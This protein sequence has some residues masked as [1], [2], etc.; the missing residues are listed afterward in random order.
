MS[1]RRCPQ[2]GEEYSD[3]YRTCPFCEEEEALKRGK[4]PHRRV[5]RRVEKRR[6]T[7]GAGGV[8]LLLTG[9]IILGVVGYV[10]FGDDVADAVGIRLPADESAVA[11]EDRE[12]DKIPVSQEGTVNT[13]EPVVPDTPATT[14]DEPQVNEPQDEEPAAPPAEPEPLAL[15][16]TDITI[17]AGETGRLT[18]T[19][20]SG[21]ITWTSSNPEIASVDGGAVTGKA[22]GTVTITAASGE[23][24]VTCQVK[25][26]GDPWVDPNAASYRLSKSDFTLSSSESSWQLKIKRDSATGWEILG[27]ADGVTWASSN[28]AAVTVTDTGEVKRAGKGMATVTATIGG[29]TL[30]CIVRMA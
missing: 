25:V 10:V 3:T 15:S 4:T 30:E 29:T 20:G 12:P 17:P 24:S 9:L 28:T 7:G 6:S 19:G 14:D 8:M 23:E 16:Q 22:G 1:N 2:C 18:A 21:E 13:D 5:G 27:S 26:E 11:Q